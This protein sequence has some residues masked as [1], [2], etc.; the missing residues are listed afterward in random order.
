MGRLLPYFTFHRRRRERLPVVS[1]GDYQDATARQRLFS[2]CS[3]GAKEAQA[4]LEEFQ[5]AECGLRSFPT[6]RP[7]R[8]RGEKSDSFFTT[9]DTKFTKEE[10]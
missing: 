7:Q 2:R 8:L 10:I 1:I 3:L 9:K 4:R 5:I 6:R